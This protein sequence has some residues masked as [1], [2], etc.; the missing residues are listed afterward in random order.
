MLITSLNDLECSQRNTDVIW[1]DNLYFITCIQQSKDHL[2]L[3][4]I[5]TSQLTTF[6]QCNFSLC[7]KNTKAYKSRKSDNYHKLHVIHRSP[8]VIAQSGRIW[9]TIITQN[10]KLKK[11]FT[12]GQSSHLTKYPPCQTHYNKVLQVIKKKVF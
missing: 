7:I 1:S 10:S 11:G 6:L 3:N 9:T 2:F 5:F 4:Y 8:N 12:L